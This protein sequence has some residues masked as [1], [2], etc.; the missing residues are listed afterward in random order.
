M[1]NKISVENL[2]FGWQNEPLFSNVSCSLN[3]GEMVLLQGD[4]GCG[5]TTFLKLLT[6]MIPHFS[7][8]R[9]LEG[10]ILIEGQSIIKNAPKHF[11]PKIAFFPSRNIDFFLLNGCLEEETALIQAV[12]NL[13]ESSLEE[14]RK[15]LMEIF[16]ELERLWSCPFS[17][18]DFTDKLVCLMAV[19]FIQGADYFLMDEIFKNIPE[20][21]A[22][23]WNVL[24]DYL[25]E[26]KCAVVLTAYE[27]LKSELPVWKIKNGALQV[28]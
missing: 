12:L 21:R 10:E 3:T 17:G 2:T 26:K 11:F 8:G 1:V 4:N 7:S 25:L 27:F 22:C 13:E 23:S 19:Y 5:K 15:E 18:M 6:G 28:I 20:E 16:P 14:R 24:F 9:M